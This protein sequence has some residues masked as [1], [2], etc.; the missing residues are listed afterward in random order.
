M[1][2]VFKILS[3]SIKSGQYRGQGVS[4]PA[5]IHKKGQYC[6]RDVKSTT[7]VNKNH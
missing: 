4:I 7:N 3:P 2:G 6:G 5:T 1:D